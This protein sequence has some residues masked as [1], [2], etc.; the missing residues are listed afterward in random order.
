[1]QKEQNAKEGAAKL[2][3]KNPPDQRG[4]IRRLSLGRESL[5]H[6]ATQHRVLFL[7]SKGGGTRE[8]PFQ[9]IF[10]TEKMRKAVLQATSS[11]TYPAL[12]IS[13]CTLNW[14]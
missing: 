5:N 4:G 11:S 10:T 9:K 12:K 13:P 8:G 7:M 2:V 3:S 1:M 14:A 6:G